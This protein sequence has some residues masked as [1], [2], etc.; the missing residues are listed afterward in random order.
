MY[1]VYQ[2]DFD[3]GTSYVGQSGN[4]HNRIQAHKALWKKLFGLD[5]NRVR[6]LKFVPTES[7][8]LKYESAYIK[9]YG[10]ENLRNKTL[11]EFSEEEALNLS[12]QLEKDEEPTDPLTLLHTCDKIED[13]ETRYRA[14][15]R[16]LEQLENR[17]IST[18]AKYLDAKDNLKYVDTI[19][20]EAVRRSLNDYR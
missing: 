10:L 8:A 20:D 16:K 3:D 15:K 6:I 11:V 12:K 18:Y 17:Y 7:L 4:L 9:E 2:L 1:F 19:V 14:M 5:I 13:L